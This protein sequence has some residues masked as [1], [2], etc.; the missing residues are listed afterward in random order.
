MPQAEGYRLELTY[1]LPKAEALKMRDVFRQEGFRAYIGEIMGQKGMYRVSL[2]TFS[3]NAVA[4]TLAKGIGKRLTLSTSVASLDSKAAAYPPPDIRTSYWTLQ[5]EM[6]S[7]KEHA[8]TYRDHWYARGYPYYVV[9]LKDDDGKN[10]WGTR[11]GLFPDKESAQ[12]T[13]DLF[14]QEIGKPLIPKKISHTLLVERVVGDLPELLPTLPSE[15]D[16]A[17]PSPRPKKIQ[18]EKKA[19]KP[20]L[21]KAPRVDQ[22]SKPEAAAKPAPKPKAKPTATP[23]TKT[24]DTGKSAVKTSPA[25]EKKAI[26]TAF[27]TLHSDSF[28]YKKNALN[29]RDHWKSKGYP[30]YVLKVL[31][32]NGRTWWVTRMGQYAS[33]EKAR[34]AGKE[35]T[36][37][38]GKKTFLRH[39]KRALYERRLVQ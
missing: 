31:D 36:Q 23:K 19:D 3:K 34:R 32:D 9:R 28:T 16:K 35:F 27:W 7:K 20:A 17:G 37:H 22:Q 18:T 30:F 33:K 11:L 13:A 8:T 29:E 4:K 5:I 24:A 14:S 1:E 25:A 12:R 26:P 21:Q 10:W 15:D 6:C 38:E 39:M 2:G